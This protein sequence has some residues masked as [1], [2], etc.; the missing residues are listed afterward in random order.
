MTSKKNERP[1]T[2]AILGWGSLIWD[3]RPEFDQYHDKW[4]PD[5]PVLPLEFSRISE[6]RQGAL[7]LVVDPQHGVRCTVAYA[8]STRSNPDDAIE[9]LRCREGTIMRHMGFYFRDGSQ[10]CAPPVPGS[11]ATWAAD[12][13]Y[14]VVVWTGLPSNFKDKTG[15]EFSIAAAISHL[16]SLTNEGKSMAATYVWR[17][18]DLIQTPLRTAL[19][20]EPW[21]SVPATTTD[22][23]Q[24]AAT[25]PR[26]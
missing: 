7:T 16:Q 22:A 26:R 9:D 19:Q 14:D 2:I 8:L 20:I 13:G 4:Q 3:V 6:S 10:T 23:A 12:K 5:G 17:A 21:F 25:G 11:I 24:A 18:P 1:N 15:K